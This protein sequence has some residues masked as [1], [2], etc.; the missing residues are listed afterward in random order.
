LVNIFY[1][2]WRKIRK[3]GEINNTFGLKE[4]NTKIAQGYFLLILRRKSV[5]NLHL[6]SEFICTKDE[7]E[8][9]SYIIA[10]RC[11]FYVVGF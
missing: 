11:Y 10:S 4:C 2:L 6:F 8:V 5:I 9:F 1:I 3:K 7:T